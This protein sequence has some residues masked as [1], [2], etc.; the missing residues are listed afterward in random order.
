MNRLS[1]GVTTDE[2]SQMLFASARGNQMRRRKFI[3]GLAG[4]AVWP[5]AARAQQ[6]VPPIIGLLSISSSGNWTMPMSAFK[7][8]LGEI[9]YVVGRNVRIEERW[10]EGQ[11]DRLPAL[12]ADLLRHQ[13]AVVFAGGPPAVL[14]AKAQTSTIPIVF[15]VGEDPVKEGLVASLNRPG[16]NVT[17]FTDFNNQLTGKRLGLLHEVVPKA[18]VVAFLLNPNNPNAEP[19]TRDARAAA[20]TLWLQL[21]VVTAMTESELEPAF[22]AMVQQGVG[23]LLIG[24]DSGIRPEKVV[25]LAVRHAIPAIYPAR[26]YPVVGGLMSYG[27]SKAEAWHQAGI[28]VGRIL[29]GESP[30]D[31]PAQQA[32]K[33]EFVFNLKTAKTLGL[34][35]P[36]TLLAVTDEVID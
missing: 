32:T 36:P 19:D 16:G 30:A 27:A 12:T 34:E 6:S 10:A 7:R 18:D 1:E 2:A 24:V 20:Q 33:F 4:V 21:R 35:I 31:L 26:D 17:G 22:A 23:A 14:A 11:F 15:Y 28:Y 5:L 8:G 9:G 25:A 3:A 29:K 13:V